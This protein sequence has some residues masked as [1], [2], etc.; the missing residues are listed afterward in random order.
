MQGG[1]L[2]RR[3]VSPGTPIIVL[4]GSCV[5]ISGAA[6]AVITSVPMMINPSLADGLC[7]KLRAASI[8]KLDE[9]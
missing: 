4:M 7:S 8:H 5:A 9:R 2:G 1:L 3:P 6:I